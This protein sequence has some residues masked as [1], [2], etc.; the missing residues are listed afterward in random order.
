MEK[1]KQRL[2]KVSL[3]PLYSLLMA[4]VIGGIII[5]GSGNNPFEI[6]GKLITGALGTRNGILQT[7][8]QST[9]LIFCGLSVAFGMR[10]GVLNLGVEGQLY[11]GA[12]AATLV[13]LGGEGLPSVV[14]IPLCLVAGM[15]GGA[16]WS[17]LPI[18]LKLKRGVHE[19]VTA[20]MSRSMRRRFRCIP[21]SPRRITVRTP[22]RSGRISRCRS[23]IRSA[24]RL[25]WKSWP[26]TVLIH[27]W[28]PGRERRCAVS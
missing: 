8:L 13:A 9:P 14:L 7:L 24:G 26:Q 28:R 3:T 21:I 2:K 17:L 18:V 6:Y 20:L 1:L 23:T 25:F 5:L 16:V 4:L 10:G 19:V 15:L 22:G 11:M 12:L 27:L